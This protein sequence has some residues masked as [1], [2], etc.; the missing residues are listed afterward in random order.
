MMVKDGESVYSCASQLPRRAKFSASRRPLIFTL[1]EYP[2]LCYCQ[3]KLA[4]ALIP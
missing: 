1:S 2:Y 3:L 4:M